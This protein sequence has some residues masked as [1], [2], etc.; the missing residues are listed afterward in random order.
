MFRHMS[1]RG[2]ISASRCA[3]VFRPDMAKLHV[4]R[5]AALKSMRKLAGTQDLLVRAIALQPESAVSHLNL[6][7]VLS[8]AGALEGALETYQHAGLLVPGDI[9]AH[10]N[11]GLA[12][13]ELG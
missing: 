12:L 10:C 2:L 3:L 9:A 1:M 4:N 11:Q 6:D 8:A 13:K 5:F 7:N